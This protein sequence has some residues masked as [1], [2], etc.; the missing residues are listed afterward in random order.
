MSKYLISISTFKKNDALTNL[1][2]S[3]I[4]TGALE[5][6]FIHISDDNNSG[7]KEVFDHFFATFP[8][9]FGYSTSP[10]MGIWGNKNR[11]IYYFL[12]RNKEPEYCLLLDDDIISVG[13]GLCQEFEA[14]SKFSGQQQLSSYL[15][16]ADM[17][18]AGRNK[19]DEIL[20]NGFFK[21]FP[22]VA[23]NEY[24]YWCG[25]AQGIAC[26]YTRELLQKLGYMDNLGG[27]YGYEHALHA[28]R[29]LR[30]QGFC[31]E[32]FPMIKR[33]P[34]F[35]KT[36]LIPNAYDVDMVKVEGIQKTNYL[37]RLTE[38]YQG[39]NLNVSK[40]GFNPKKE[41]II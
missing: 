40:P 39:Y 37:K 20:Q 41:I 18:A 35:F 16:D 34:N 38:T 25:G 5:D 33:S 26:F 11:G 22:I 30:I 8:K 32:L 7:A 24:L 4:S 3:L 31:P 29:A 23:E 36:Q 1:I 28:A 13:S 6:S 17:V 27:P 9:S 21:T 15:G 10:R 14:A 12:E 2:E 19:E